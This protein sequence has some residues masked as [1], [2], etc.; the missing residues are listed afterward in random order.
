M[1]DYGKSEKRE[2][3]VRFGLKRN[4]VIAVLIFI[5]LVLI[6]VIFNFDENILLFIWPFSSITL[7]GI[8][9]GVV[10]TRAARP[11]AAKIN[12]IMAGTAFV[13]MGP[14]LVVVILP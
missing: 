10:L 1:L 8:Y 2:N 14:C 11:K 6:T 7:S 13:I 4:L 9:N 12:W 5:G 3:T